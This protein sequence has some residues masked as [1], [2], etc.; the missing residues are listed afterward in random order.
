MKAAGYKY[1]IRHL[2]LPLVFFV[3]AQ[4]NIAQ[5]LIPFVLNSATLYSRALST[6]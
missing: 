2:T 5:Y 6:W 1:N 4:L 3:M